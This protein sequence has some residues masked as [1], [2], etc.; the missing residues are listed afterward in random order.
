MNLDISYSLIEY[1][2]PKCSQPIEVLLK[3]VITE[4]IVI[5]PNCLIDIQL[6]DKDGSCGRAQKDID[7]ALDDFKRKIERFG[8]H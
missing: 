2:C 1:K 4:E 6:L 7:K 5:C 8:G 3:Q